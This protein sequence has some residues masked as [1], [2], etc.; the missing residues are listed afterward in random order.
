MPPKNTP[1][2]D[3]PAE[4]RP[5]ERLL[6]NGPRALSNA[7]LLAILLRTGSDNENVLRLAQRILS[8]FGGLHHLAGV[9]PAELMNIRG[10]GE[11]KAAQVAAALE[12]GN[13]LAASQP[14]ERPQVRQAADAAQL[15]LDMRYLSQEH[16][17][18]ILLDNQNRVMAIPTVYIG[19]NNT[20]VLRV[21]EVFREAITRNS[22]ALIVVH[23]HP[24]GDPDPS[25]EDITFTRDMVRA[26]ELLD[27]H[28]TDHII[29]GE[30]EWRSLRELGLGFS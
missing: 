13:R 26:G 16:V 14:A 29:I 25:P 24:A 2:T 21:A 22:P 3:L 1:L 23:N 19:T 18:L 30:R 10:L 28:V 27:I 4:E 8:H 6:R 17:R 15:V 7:E 9:S 20:S 5:R 12:I 11:A